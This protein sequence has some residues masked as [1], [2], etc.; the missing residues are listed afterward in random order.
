MS[1][2]VLEVKNLTVA[3]KFQNVM[4]DNV[5]MDVRAGEIVGIAN[6]TELATA[7]VGLLSNPERWRA[8]QAAGITRV[9]RYYTQEQ[10]FGRYRSVYEECLNKSDALAATPTSCPR[11]N[12]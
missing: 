6:P 10:M 4:V 11:G 12:H 2:P 3:D 7:I 8:A 1:E 9:E 5:S